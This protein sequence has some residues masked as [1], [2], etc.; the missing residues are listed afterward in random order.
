M[1][2][3]SYFVCVCVCMDAMTKREKFILVFCE[4][5]VAFY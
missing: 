1:P 5:A 3:Y 2:A 4:N